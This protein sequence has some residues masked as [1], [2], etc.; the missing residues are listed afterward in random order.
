MEILFFVL[1]GNEI[2]LEFIPKNLFYD[3]IL[4]FSNVIHLFFIFKYIVIKQDFPNGNFV[5]CVIGNEISLE[6]IP[7]NLFYDYIFFIHFIIIRL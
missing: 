3:Y 4:L 5:F 1:G 2:S 7:K 6:F